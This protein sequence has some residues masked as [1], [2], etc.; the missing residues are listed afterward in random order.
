MDAAR[1]ASD[2]PAKNKAS[3]DGGFVVEVF[4]ELR[5]SMPSSLLAVFLFRCFAQSVRR[6]GNRK[7]TRASQGAATN[8]IDP[9]PL[10][11]VKTSDAPSVTAES[12]RRPWQ[13]AVRPKENTETQTPSPECSDFVKVARASGKFV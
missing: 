7:M 2:G 5:Y 3:A 8:L 13:S 11:S 6:W 4:R 10:E 12:G 9:C 1:R